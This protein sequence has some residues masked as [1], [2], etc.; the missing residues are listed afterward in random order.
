MRAGADGSETGVIR[1]VGAVGLY[2]GAGMTVAPGG[3]AAAVANVAG[4]AAPP[5]VC[6]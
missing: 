5:A 2:V 6:C 3:A 4:A 1:V